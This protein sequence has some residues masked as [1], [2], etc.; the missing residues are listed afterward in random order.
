MIDCTSVDKNKDCSKIILVFLRKYDFKWNYHFCFICEILT[1]PNKSFVW[2]LKWDKKKMQC[3]QIVNTDC[4]YCKTVNIT[5]SI[6]I[7]FNMD[8]SSVQN[9]YL[10]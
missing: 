2:K 9:Q 8:F 6:L 5:F 10:I 7:M 1:I 3:T 4:E